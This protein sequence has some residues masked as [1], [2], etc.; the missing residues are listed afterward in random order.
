LK[1]LLEI[2]E[3]IGERGAGFQSLAEDI[4]LTTPAGRL[5]AL[6]HPPSAIW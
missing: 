2:V 6:E 5:V 3:T 1:D 4:Y